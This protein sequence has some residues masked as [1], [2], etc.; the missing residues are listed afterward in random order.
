MTAVFIFAALIIPAQANGFLD[1]VSSSIQNAAGDYISDVGSTLIG[2]IA[3]GL[4]FIIGYIAG[5]LF[6]I[7]GFLINF[8][9]ELNSNILNENFNTFLYT[10]WNIV[11]GFANLAFILA[12]IVIA[13][14]TIIRSQTYGMKQ[15]LWRLIVA[16]LL[17]NF[18]LVI[19]GVFIDAAGL[20]TNFFVSKS[21]L[22]PSD[23]STTLA[24]VFDVQKFMEGSG[25]KISAN[26]F[27]SFS[28]NTLIA[29][30]SVFFTFIFTMIASIVLL[31]IFVMLLARYVALSF[32]LIF[33][34]LVLVSWVFPGTR[35]AWQEWWKNFIKWTIFAP[36]MTFFLYLSIIALQSHPGEVLLN[37]IDSPAKQAV[38]SKGFLFAIGVIGQMVMAVG[39][40]LASLFYAQRLGIAGGNK[41][42]GMAQKATKGVGNFVGGLAGRAAL[43]TAGAAGRGVLRGV[44]KYATG[45]EG[46][47]TA[48]ENLASKE[49]VFARL[50]ARGMSALTQGTQKGIKSQLE[51]EA[52]K[53]DDK[54]LNLK[55]QTTRGPQ[56]AIYLN[57]A[58]KRKKLDSKVAAQIF[59]DPRAVEELETHSKRMGLD[60]K[61][62][63]KYMGFSAQMAKEAAK[64]GADFDKNALYKA[65][66][67]FYGK[68]KPVDMA[69]IKFHDL[70]NTDA[71]KELK[72]PLDIIEKLRAAQIEGL[73]KSKN[74][75]AVNKFYT[76]MTAKQIE[77]FDAGVN[78]YLD[79]NDPDKEKYVEMSKKAKAKRF[80]G[81]DKEKKEKLS[82]ESK[83][84][85]KAE[86]S[87]DE[88]ADEEDETY[89]T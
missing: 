46:Y 10:G 50:T 11:L 86:K 22:G 38:G 57:E 15:I 13:F 30:S 39:I 75:L 12:I 31:A 6:S 35:S 63:E 85:E 72:M 69:S 18:S 45:T 19:A 16:A 55:T 28:A 64:S 76:N 26:P 33:S 71:V 20:V 52:K 68:M 80:F 65:S 77:E 9:L 23:M 67:E 4:N 78:L 8:A 1:T 36:V 41:F 74:M 88:S 49:N 42:Y 5:I 24:S 47:K 21:T 54:N 56:R 66:E 59:S 17:V 60:F 3:Y 7:G 84:G 70:Y 73:A 58:V 79:K 82:K 83:S 29:I 37:S 44:S 87:V 48:T 89:Q 51:D 27:E 43:G 34:P 2:K 40:L 61:D 62:V 32:L 53:L 81:K 14:A 25:N